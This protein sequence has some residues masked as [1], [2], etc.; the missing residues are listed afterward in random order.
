MKSFAPPGTR[1]RRPC[2]AIVV[3]LLLAA[4][5]TQTDR[6]QA[7]SK[8]SRDGEPQVTD[9]APLTGMFFYMADAAS[10]VDC[11]GG[12]RYPVAQEGDYLALERAYLAA[13]PEP[14][15]PLRVRI[16]GRLEDRPPMEGEGMRPTI[17]VERFMDL[18]AQTTCSD[19]GP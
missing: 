1:G 7:V 15:T 5:G 6:G 10:F 14:G 17:I 2:G 13:R 9:D 11:E 18:S 19:S 16:A 12:V 4:C 8:G 3:G